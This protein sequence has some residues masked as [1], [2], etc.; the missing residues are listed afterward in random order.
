MARRFRQPLVMGRL[1]RDL[2]QG[3][4]HAKAAVVLAQDGTACSA[5]TSSTASR[6]RRRPRRSSTHPAARAFFTQFRSPYGATS[7]RSSPSRTTETGVDQSR[8]VSLPGTV[9]RWVL[10]PA[11]PSLASGRTSALSPRLQRL[12]RY[13]LGSSATPEVNRDAHRDRPVGAV[14]VAT[15]SRRPRSVR[16]RAGVRRLQ[17]EAE[18]QHEDECDTEPVPIVGHSMSRLELVAET[19]TGSFAVSMWKRSK[20]ATTGA[21][22]SPSP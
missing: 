18:A 10:R 3:A 9:R 6:S 1:E 4:R 14:S 15:G 12:L 22:Y 21:A 7:H 2:E 13:G 20:S 16:E 11:S 17:R 5:S 19:V 8:P